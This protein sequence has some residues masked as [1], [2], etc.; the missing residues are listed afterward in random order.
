MAHNTLP[1]KRPGTFYPK[2]GLARLGLMVLM[3]VL[4]LISFGCAPEQFLRTS[5]GLKI[6]YEYHRAKEERGTAVLLHGYGSNLDEWYALR[7]FLNRRGW[8]TM[9]IDFR[10]H[11][12]SDESPSHQRLASMAEQK[13][14]D[15][16]EMTRDI[17]AALVAVDQSKPIWLI[18]SSLGANLALEAAGRHP[19]IAGLVLLS[20]VSSYGGLDSVS[21]LSGL[22]KRPVFFAASER[23][24][25]G[26]A[27]ICKDLLEKA[28][29][30]K[31]L[32]VY[33]D[34]GHG[35]EMFENESKLKGEIL[36]WLN[37]NIR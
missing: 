14:Y 10:N 11:G 9:A 28:Q 31:K 8:S 34:A 25:S 20:P 33:R 24:P 29:G 22:G 3:S 13:G 37:Q 12:S 2:R 17:D 5:D 35:S 18:G 4:S 16:N 15:L 1:P 36:S 30:K 21:A 23:D 26:A 7:R 19:E 27:K 6:A 32:R